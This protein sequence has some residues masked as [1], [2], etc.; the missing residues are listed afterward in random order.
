MPSFL[1]FFLTPQVGI[2]EG[3]LLNNGGSGRVYWSAKNKLPANKAF[4]HRIIV[5]LG[6]E[7]TLRILKLQ[8][9]HHRQ[10]HQPPH[11][12]SAQAAQSP[13]QP[14]LDHFQGWT[15]HPSG[16]LFQHLTSLIVKNFPL[17]SSL[18]LPTS[19]PSDNNEHHSHQALHA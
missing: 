8:P 15:G 11:L 1:P 14:G 19:N 18:N 17:I 5:W 10:D 16:Q 4:D 12:I 2:L 9:P 13:I 3:M 7:W 6:L